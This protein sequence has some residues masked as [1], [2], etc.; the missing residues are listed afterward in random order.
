MRARPPHAGVFVVLCMTLLLPLR[1]GAAQAP[2]AKP[3]AVLETSRKL[4]QQ[5]RFCSF[6]TLGP[7]GRA[8][9]RIVDPMPP[10]ADMTV[11]VATNPVT[12][13]VEQVRKNPH[14]TL[15]YWDAASMGYVTLIGDATL[16]DDPAE[17]P[18]HWKPDW[19]AFYSDEYRGP[20]FTLIRVTPRRLEIVSYA[21]GLL[22]DPKTWRPVQ[23][24]FP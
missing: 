5:A 1:S 18:K 3:P 2:E 6:I 15:F 8:E 14:V 10:E 12:R 19:S 13:K 21:D 20:D 9:A 4:M 16:V 24:E 7:D 22:N 23:Y 17:K 11:W